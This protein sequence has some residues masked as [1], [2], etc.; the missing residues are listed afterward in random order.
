MAI[1][2]R[3]TESDTHVL[4]IFD[5]G[6]GLDRSGVG[7]WTGGMVKTIPYMAWDHPCYVAHTRFTFPEISNNARETS[8]SALP[9]L[10]RSPRESI[11]T[12]L[13]SLVTGRRRTWWRDMS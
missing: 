1:S 5:V 7:A 13:P 2:L 4:P 8:I 11:P 9:H 6:N 12:S 10:A 3:Y